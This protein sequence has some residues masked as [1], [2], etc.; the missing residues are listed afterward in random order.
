MELAK[1]VQQFEH[2]SLLKLDKDERSSLEPILTNDTM[3][4]LINLALLQI[5]R[6]KSVNILVNVQARSESN[7]DTINSYR[8]LVSK[9]SNM[10]IEEVDFSLNS[11]EECLRK[12]NEN[13]ES[14][15]GV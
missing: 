14:K 7:N 15:S 5:I 12:D 3:N 1:I 9:L 8:R 6:K 10:P 4:K 13:E 2:E 11:I